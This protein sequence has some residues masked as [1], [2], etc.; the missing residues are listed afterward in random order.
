[1]TDDYHVRCPFVVE[2]C[3]PSTRVN[4]LHFI[5]IACGHCCQYQRLTLAGENTNSMTGLLF[6][7]SPNPGC[8]C[9]NNNNVLV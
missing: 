4:S 9:T 5:E 7:E 3:P 1:M 8:S 6:M 2:E